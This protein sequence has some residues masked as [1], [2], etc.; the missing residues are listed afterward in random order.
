M[1]D[2]LPRLVK[3]GWPVAMCAF[4]GLSGSVI[5]YKGVKTYPVIQDPFGSDGFVF[6]T[7]HFNAHV[8][9]NFCDIW[10]INPQHLQAL[11]NMKI[12][13]IPYVP[14]DQEPVSPQVLDRLRFAHKI[15]TFSK[16]GQ[17]A[18]EKSGFSSTM[19]WEGV[20]T[21]VFKPINK[22]ECRKK[23]GLPEGKF[24]FGMIGANKENPSRKGWQEALEAFKL[25]S[26]KHPDSALF[27]Q[28]NQNIPSGFPILDYS[29][30]LGILD[31]VFH[32]DEYTSLIHVGPKE[33]AEILNACDVLLHP[34]ATEGFGLISVEAMSCGTPVIVNDSTSMPEMVID[35]VTGMICNSGKQ[36]FSPAQGF[37]K[38]ADVQSLYEK[39]EAMFVA[40]REKMGE[41]ARKHALENFDIDKLVKVWIAYFEKLQ[42]ELLPKLDN[43]KKT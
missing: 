33:V 38:M 22:E 39:M 31:K 17:K 5:D 37:W 20:D 24:I 34:S 43:P 26:D 36:F 29:K 40:D 19:I 6:H 23:F 27:Y 30:H 21:E 42:E 13:F 10:T 28:S 11:Q 16:F 4:A 9:I 41:A 35:N 7:K 8:A 14:I 12:A 15:I 32:L 18:L 1:N 3:D 2:L 25:F